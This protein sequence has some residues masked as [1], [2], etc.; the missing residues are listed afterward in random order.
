[1][2]LSGSGTSREADSHEE[3][4]YTMENNFEMTDEVVIEIDEL[5]IPESDRC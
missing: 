4:G 2:W 1:M 5:Q 3:G